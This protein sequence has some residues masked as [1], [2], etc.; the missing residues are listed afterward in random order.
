M[1]TSKKKINR[2][3]RHNRIRAKIRGTAERP[4]LVVF[5]SLSNHYAQLIDDDKGVTIASFSDLK[6]KGNDNKSVRAKKVGLELARLAKEKGITKCVFD[7]NG[8]LYHGR[9]K[10]I[11]DGAREGGL[12]F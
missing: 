8:Y 3:K 2:K 7:R 12:E 11:A 4:R 6:M 1:T 10:A 9:V 5:R